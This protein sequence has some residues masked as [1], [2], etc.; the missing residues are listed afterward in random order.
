[1]IASRRIDALR[2]LPESEWSLTSGTT[3][4]YYLFPNIQLTWFDGSASMVKIYPHP[5]DPGKSITKVMHYFSQEMIDLASDPNVHAVSADNTYD[6]DAIAQDQQVALTLESVME[7]FDSTV[8]QEDY[9]MG[10]H[11][12]AASESGELEHLIFGRNE[13]ALH[14]YHNHFRDALGMPPLEKIE[15]AA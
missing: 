15:P 13:P 10:K 5:T 7:V 14:H 6:R 4:L 1:M 11:Q 8:E 3:P 2:E 12:Q 9:L